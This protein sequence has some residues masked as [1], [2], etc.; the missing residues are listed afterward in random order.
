MRQTGRR[1]FECVVTSIAL[2]AMT[3]CLT[4]LVVNE[5]FVGVGIFDTERFLDDSNNRRD[6]AQGVGLI[7]GS[8]TA[9][10]GYV[11]YEHIVVPLDGRSVRIEG[12]TGTVA[13]GEAAE[14][15][16]RGIANEGRL[17]ASSSEVT[18]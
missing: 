7:L 9:S 14:R 13:V 18:Q 16:A 6:F 11:E 2:S 3:G 1:T 10:L 8:G 15:S 5:Q 12:R 4:P 17:S